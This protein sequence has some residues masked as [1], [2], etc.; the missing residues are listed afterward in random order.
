MAPNFGTRK[1]DGPKLVYHN[2]RLL[3]GW[4]TS[5]MCQ[6]ETTSETHKRTKAWLGQIGPEE[7]AGD[8][9]SAHVAAIGFLRVYVSSDG[10]DQ[11]YNDVTGVNEAHPA[12]LDLHTDTTAV[13]SFL[14]RG[15]T[16][17]LKFVNRRFAGVRNGEREYCE[18]EGGELK[19]F[20]RNLD[21][22]DAN[23]AEE[24]GSEDNETEDNE[25]DEDEAEHSEI[26]HGETEGGETEGGEADGGE[27]DQSETEQ[28]EL[29]GQRE[30]QEQHEIQ[31]KREVQERAKKE[32]EKKEKRKRAS[33]VSSPRSDGGG[34]KRRRSKPAVPVY[35]GKVHDEDDND[36]EDAIHPKT[37]EPTVS[38]LKSEE[39]VAHQTT[40]DDDY[41]VRDISPGIAS[42]TMTESTPNETAQ[43][44]KHDEGSEQNEHL[45]LM[46]SAKALAA[47]LKRQAET[48]IEPAKGQNADFTEHLSALTCA[49]SVEEVIKLSR[50]VLVRINHL[51]NVLSN[52]F[53]AYEQIVKNAEARN[54][55]DDVLARHKV[56]VLE[57]KA[58]EVH[59]R[60][61]YMALKTQTEDL[62]TRRVFQ[63]SAP[64]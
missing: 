27:A 26:E 14:E 47:E 62:D 23:E 13:A 7:S 35:E 12:I 40:N 49:S 3:I 16:G 15:A 6:A 38:I 58:E 54:K 1:R 60:K 52:D 46:Q 48:L 25:S 28:R 8:Y 36:G 11:L 19:R 18:R 21:Q 61:V 29:Q 42:M 63:R 9:K 33:N 51:R 10:P 17:R 44:A 45:T 34:G 59:A 56:A 32:A 50:E 31:E 53:I 57:Y 4:R 39:A 37:E 22:V 24:D 43:L 2:D 20:E 30:L 5:K 41:V 64:K 55:P